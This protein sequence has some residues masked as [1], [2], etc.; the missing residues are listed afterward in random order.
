MN[1]EQR[2]KET[3]FIQKVLEMQAIKAQII[4]LVN[5]NETARREINLLVL[6]IS[7]NEDS[8][9]DLKTKAKSI[10]QELVWE[11]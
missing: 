2:M 3:E 9:R 5:M 7:E 11:D 10:L 4:E 6:Q 1:R 8:I